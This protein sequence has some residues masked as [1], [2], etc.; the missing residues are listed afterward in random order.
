M[1]SIESVDLIKLVTGILSLVSA[2]IILI[3]KVVLH[4]S[5]H[6]ISREHNTRDYYIEGMAYL[7]MGV[8]FILIAIAVIYL[9]MFIPNLALASATAFLIFYVISVYYIVKGTIMIF[10]WLTSSVYHGILEFLRKKIR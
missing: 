9:L 6:F 3:R 8:I 10:R 5:E 1:D 7:I 4:K 2:F